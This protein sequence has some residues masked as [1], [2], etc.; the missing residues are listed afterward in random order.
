MCSLRIYCMYA[1]THTDMYTVTDTQSFQIHPL[2][3]L[4][5]CS[6]FISETFDNCVF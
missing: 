6:A 1:S 2:T 5:S 3:S 4:E